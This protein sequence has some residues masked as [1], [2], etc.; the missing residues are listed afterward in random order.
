MRPIFRLRV[1]GNTS[2]ARSTRERQTI[3]VLLTAH[4]TRRPPGTSSRKPLDSSGLPE[5][6]TIDQSGANTAARL[7]YAKE[8]TAPSLRSV[9][10]KH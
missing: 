5:R 6:V 9:K 7:M 10:S 2:I 1:S 3:D 4:V 8:E